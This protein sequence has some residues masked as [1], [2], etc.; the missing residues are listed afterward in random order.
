MHEAGTFN[1]ID[2]VGGEDLVA[3]RT[4][5]LAF[6][7]VLVACEVREQRQPSI[8]APLSSRTIS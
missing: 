4:W 1:G 7:G 5:N 8:S 6:Y 3:F 2:I